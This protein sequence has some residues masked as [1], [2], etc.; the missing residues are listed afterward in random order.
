MTVKKAWTNASAALKKRGG[1]QLD[2]LLVEVLLRLLAMTPCLFLL[3]DNLK[4]L[5]LL[6]AV[7][8]ILLIPV[9]RCNSAA[10]MQERL[11]GGNLFSTGLVNRSD[12]GKKLAGGLKTGL[13]LILWALPFLAATAFVY[14]VMYGNTVV[15]KTDVFS[16]LMALSNLGGGD[17][18]RGAVLAIGLYV[19]TLVPFVF[20]LSF[21]SA[22]RH[23][24]ALEDK[25]LIRGRRGGAIRVW[26]SGVL[27]LLPFILVAAYFG[28]D[29]ARRL[30]Q[31]VNNLASSG[32]HLPSLDRG[33]YYILAAFVIFVLPVTPLRSMLTAAYVQGGK[34]DKHAA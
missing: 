31:A 27:L 4:I 9:A 7:L 34:E 12:Y 17:I 20:G 6:S 28:L 11:S 29:Y 16:V 8:W 24:R 5:A 14:R 30:I 13:C 15:G 22:N 33:I 21:H 32:L 19:L 25:T 1:E 2:F 18:M 26:W 3:T 23:C 10:A